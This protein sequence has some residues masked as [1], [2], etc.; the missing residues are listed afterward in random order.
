MFILIERSTVVIRPNYDLNKEVI[1]PKITRFDI[2]AKYLPKTVFSFGG[3]FSKKV[4]MIFG[5][6]SI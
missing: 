3:H 2:S 5:G 1:F 4:C 6:H